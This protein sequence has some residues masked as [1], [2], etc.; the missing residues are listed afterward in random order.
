MKTL[1]A[2]GRFVDLLY[3]LCICYF[4]DPSPVVYSLQINTDVTGLKNE[5]K[6]DHFYVGEDEGMFRYPDK[7]L[8]GVGLTFSDREY[9]IIRLIARGL[10]SEEIA[11]RLFVSVHTVN[12]HRRNILD[13]TGNRSTLELVIE[14]QEKGMI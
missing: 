2:E 14:L 3:Q 13:K 11:K 8:L 5:I 7:S 10:H 9:E 12:T 4:D 6:H 1:N